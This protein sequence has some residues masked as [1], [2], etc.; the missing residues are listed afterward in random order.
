MIQDVEKRLLLP[1]KAIQQLFSKLFNH[2]GQVLTKWEKFRGRMFG[3][4]LSVLNVRPL[5][6]NFHVLKKITVVS[7]EA[8]TVPGPGKYPVSSAIS[9]TGEQFFSTF[10]SSCA[11]KFNPPKSKRFPGIRI[12][13]LQLLSMW[14][15]NGS[16]CGYKLART[17]TL[18]RTWRF[19]Q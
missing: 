3:K 6:S 9:P 19:G 13:F 7:K 2:P 8:K 17:R 1:L 14:P 18:S 12:D 16:N 10:S 15:A 5:V 11:P 4:L